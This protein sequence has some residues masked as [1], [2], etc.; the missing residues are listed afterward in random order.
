MAGNVNVD[1]LNAIIFVYLINNHVII[2]HLPEPAY[3]LQAFKFS[4]RYIRNCCLIP[5]GSIAMQ[6]YKLLIL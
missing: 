1:I 5:T 3:F 4:C 2:V 6:F